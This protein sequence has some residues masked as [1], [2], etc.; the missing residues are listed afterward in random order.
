MKHLVVSIHDVSPLTQAATEKI[1]GEL[2]ALGVTRTSL[3]VVPNHH[4]RAPFLQDP[5]FCAWLVAQNNLGHEIVLH[6]YFHQRVRRSRESLF[7]KITTQFYTADEGEFY[8]LDEAA[9]RDLVQKT[10][11]EFAEIGLQ[12]CG[13]IAP[14]WLLS[15]A[16]ERALRSLGLIY[17]TRLATIFHLPTSRVHP[18]QSLVWSVRNDW[19]RR[20]SLRWN[21][22]L[23]NR[24]HANPLLRVSIH[25]PDCAHAEIWAQIRALISA[26]LA[27]RTPTTYQDWT[28]GHA[29]FSA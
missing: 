6:G 27:E 11:R 18:S 4:H 20:V 25:P 29:D 24:L 28:A 3:L 19:R 14:A 17:T 15:V 10:R 5:E 8:D 7:A 9:A 13:F 16:A 1:L 12:P 22:F 2:R 21:A 23:N 26:A